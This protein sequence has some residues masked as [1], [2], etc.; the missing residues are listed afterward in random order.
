[1][2]DHTN[3]NT[4]V[5]DTVREVPSTSSSGGSTA[6]I[7]GALAVA[8]LVIVWAVLS[9]ADAPAPSGTAPTDTNN[10]TIEAPAAP[11]AAAP[12]ETA[13]APDAAAP[14]ETAP[15]APEAAPADGGTEPAAPP[16]SN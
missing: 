3:H 15:A 7:L 16:A 8:I 1:M 4:Y 2:S 6:F 13:P 9:G 10:V 11:D 14:V 12:V 5:R